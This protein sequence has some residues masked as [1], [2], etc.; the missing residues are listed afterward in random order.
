MIPSPILQDDTSA[1]SGNSLQ[2]CISSI[3]NLSQKSFCKNGGFVP[4]FILDPAGYEASIRRFLQ[5][6]ASCTFIKAPVDKFSLKDLPPVDALPLCLVRGKSPR[7]SGGHVVVGRVKVGLEAT[8]D[9][10]LSG[11]KDIELVHDP[12]VSGAMLDKAEDYGW[13]GLIVP[14]DNHPEYAVLPPFLKGHDVK[15]GHAAVTTHALISIDFPYLTI[16]NR[17]PKVVQSVIDDN[18]F[19]ENTVAKLKGIMD[20]LRS[21]GLMTLSDDLVIHN[22]CWIMEMGKWRGLSVLQAPWWVVENWM[23]RKIVEA[24]GYYGVDPSH[25]LAAD[26]FAKSKVLAMDSSKPSFLTTVLPLSHEVAEYVTRP[27]KRTPLLSSELYSK[28]ILRSLWGNR[29]DLSLSAGK[30]EAVTGGA[31][32]IVDDT[33]ASWEYLLKAREWKSPVQVSLI[34]DNCGL[35]LLSDLVT[36]D[37]LLTSHFVDTVILHCKDAPV[38]VSD[39][40][41][42]DIFIALEWIRRLDNDLS[43]S[44]HARLTGYIRNNRLLIKK[45]HFFTSVKP[46][47]ELPKD[48][49]DVLGD[50]IITIMKGDANYRRLLGDRHFPYNAPFNSV[51]ASYFPSPILSLRTLKSNVAVGIPQAAVEACSLEDSEWLVNGKYGVIQFGLK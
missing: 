3:F 48:L 51:V 46:Y 5:E 9:G 27:D 39:A 7:G 47:W 23:Y 36:A 18:N 14:W 20:T 6:H 35:E 49:K 42:E 40:M 30:V 15:A 26:P 38:F 16:V 1:T 45:H 10:G 44:L 13:V 24:I 21:D 17:M 22:S 12:H 34:L 41:P 31:I 19:P 32:T 29:A 2:A 4:N 37:G 8:D 50:S 33:S 28:L 43:H 11:S 25:P